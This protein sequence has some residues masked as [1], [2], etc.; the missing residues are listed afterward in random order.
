MERIS[1]EELLKQDLYDDDAEI[2]IQVKRSPS[3]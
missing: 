1:L 3:P 2:N